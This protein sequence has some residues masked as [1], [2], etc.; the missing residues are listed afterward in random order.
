M[1]EMQAAITSKES[2]EVAPR[3]KNKTMGKTTM[4]KSWNNDGCC[5]NNS[6]NQL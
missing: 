3:G 4:I 2:R 5:W 1:G 6:K